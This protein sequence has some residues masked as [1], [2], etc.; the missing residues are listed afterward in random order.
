MDADE[1][2]NDMN[3]LVVKKGRDVRNP[4]ERT[5]R[6]STAASFMRVMVKAFDLDD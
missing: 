4:M 5:D 1:V 3:L 6:P 2:I